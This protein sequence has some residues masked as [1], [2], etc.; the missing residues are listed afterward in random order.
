MP[1]LNP[2]LNSLANLCTDPLHSPDVKT[3]YNNLLY[4]DTAKYYT[5]KRLFNLVYREHSIRFGCDKLCKWAPD[6]N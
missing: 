6:D 1:P 4:E 2:S 3:K 5:L